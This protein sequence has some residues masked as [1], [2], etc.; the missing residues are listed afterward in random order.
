MGCQHN[1]NG[2]TFQNNLASILRSGWETRI[3]GLSPKPIIITK[4]YSGMGWLNVEA[5]LLKIVKRYHKLNW[6]GG[7]LVKPIFV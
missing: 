5:G 1:N 7:N 2:S 4:N 6:P 3:W